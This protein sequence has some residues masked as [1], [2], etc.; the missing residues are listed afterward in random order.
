MR[1]SK[2]LNKKLVSEIIVLIKNIVVSLFSLA[3]EWITY[4]SIFLD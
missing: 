2:K 4:H 1:V 3:L